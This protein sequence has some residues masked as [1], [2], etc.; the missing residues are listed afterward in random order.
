[1]APRPRN[2]FSLIELMIAVAILGILASV[3]TIGYSKYRL[4]AR[5]AEI[6]LN[7]DQLVKGT[8]VYWETEHYDSTGKMTS[9]LWPAQN[10]IWWPSPMNMMCSYNDGKYPAWPWGWDAIPE[11]HQIGFSINGPSAMNYS[12][13]PN[14]FTTDTGSKV[15]DDIQLQA[16]GDLNCDGPPWT[17]YGRKLTVMNGMILQ[18]TGMTVYY[19]E[20]ENN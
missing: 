8:Q 17:N 13:Y 7:L 11:F 9:H 18:G 5:A 4:R 20:A 1:M 16:I 10:W 15:N 3:A 6:P 2:G 19:S 14:R 12:F